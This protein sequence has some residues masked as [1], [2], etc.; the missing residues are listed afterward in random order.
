MSEV[1]LYRPHPRQAGIRRNGPGLYLLIEDV[2]VQSQSGHPTR[3]CIPRVRCACF[4]EMLGGRVGYTRECCKGFR[5]SGLWF[6]V[7]I[8]GLWVSGIWCLVS[9]VGSRVSVFVCRVSGFGIHVQGVGSR[10]RVSGLGLDFRVSGLGVL[11]EARH[12]CAVLRDCVEGL[13]VLFVR[14][15]PWQILR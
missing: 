7:Q 15:L 9:A 13:D 4:G 14:Y 2:T 12:P 8:S 5:V 1:P 6:G 11:V 10:F 3:G